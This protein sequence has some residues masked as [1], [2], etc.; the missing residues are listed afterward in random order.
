M[1]APSN[2]QVLQWV[3][4]PG[5]AQVQYSP[6]ALAWE[7][8][9]YEV[10]PN[11]TLKTIRTPSP[12][13]ITPRDNNYGSDS[14]S[15]QPELI[16]VDG[17][18]APLGAIYH[19]TLGGGL[20]DLLL[21]SAGDQLYMHKGWA[22]KK[23]A[24]FVSIAS[25]LAVSSSIANSYAG[26]IRYPDQFLTLAGL[27]IFNTGRDQARVIDEEGN[28]FKLGFNQ[29]P[30][31]PDAMGPL[32]LDTEGRDG[33][34]PNSHGYS[35]E[36]NIGTAGDMLDN[37][38][39]GVLAGHFIYHIQYED[40]FGNLSA[41]SGPSNAVYIE[42]HKASP[43][44]GAT[45][46]AGDGVASTISEIEKTLGVEIKDVQRQ[47]LVR[48]TLPRDPPTNPA[49]SH[50]I[51]A[52]RIYRTPDID[53]VGPT[54]RFVTRL[55]TTCDFA[56]PDNTSDA[57]LGDDMMPAVPV[58]VFKVMCAHQGRLI[59]GN[60][61][62][63][64]G[65]VMRSMVG[66]PGTFTATD[67]VF[68]DSGG[69]EIT[70]L[71]SHAGSLLAF[72]ERTVYSLNDFGNPTPLTRGIG[73]VA[74][75]SI[76]VTRDGSLVWLGRDGFYAMR[77]SEIAAVSTPIARVMQKKVNRSRMRMAV[78]TVDPATG[79]YRCAVCPAGSNAQRM[80]LCY[81][82]QFWRQLDYGMHVNDWATTEDMRDLSLFL[83]MS[84][85]FADTSYSAM[86]RSK[87]HAS[88]SA[89]AAS[90]VED[91]KR[92]GPSVYVTNRETASGVEACSIEFPAVYRSGWL[93]ADPG[94]LKPINVRTMYL[95][96]IDAENQ[97]FLLR[98]F[99]NGSTK[100]E[101]EMQVTAAGLDSQTGIVTG[102][103][104]SAVLGEA[105]TQL[106]R[107]F[108][109]QLPV[110]F[111]NIHT[112]C[113]EVESTVSRTGGLVDIAAFAFDVSEATGGN[114]RAR[115]PGRKDQ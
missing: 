110:N 56:L 38:G 68:P 17:S 85:E 105:K 9:N 78:A 82:G 100:P 115:I 46:G 102:A 21:V 27:V 48:C 8:V 30:S 61:S 88:Y 57:A 76:Q 19:T 112:W 49:V 83:G 53:N 45:K 43:L 99:K 91:F 14:R 58:P 94:A 23:E 31:S 5:E 103:G 42:P 54:P 98:L 79:E 47:F 15:G 60:V 22:G 7:V 41:T 36:G 6:Q 18:E 70:A 59:I 33:Y 3:I 37:D 44:R 40:Q 86:V 93:R 92:R 90:F 108:W 10:T 65:M 72:T 51:V 28:V 20:S 75:K 113:F 62:G 35:W 25:G 80:I 114:V 32:G 26:G 69:T 81:D 87:L 39:G 50:D 111:N 107:L 97:P 55:S 109:R 71:F 63:A 52:V 66:F 64:H 77:G 11:S 104:Q 34:Y 73:C 84:A 106:P 1:S 2:Q 101:I 13:E 12:Y 89:S 95:G 16:G 67:F 74:P 96:L 24:N 29:I 4:P